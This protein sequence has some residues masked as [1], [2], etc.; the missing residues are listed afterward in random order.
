MGN[1]GGKGDG[2]LALS[3]AYRNETGALII[4]KATQK[5]ENVETVRSGSLEHVYMGDSEDR[6][7]RKASSMWV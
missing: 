7:Y 2:G 3:A 4:P 1:D 5:S 6:H